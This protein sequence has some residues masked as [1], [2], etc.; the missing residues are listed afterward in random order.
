MT[1]VTWFNCTSGIAGDMA[2]GAL[3]DAGADLAAVE[4][5]LRALPVPGWH[6]EVS[7]VLRAGLAGTRALVVL[8]EADQPHRRWATIR[9]LLAGAELPDR[10]RQRALDT[11]RLLAEVEGRLHGV[12]PEDVHFHEVGAVDSIVDVVGVCLALEDLDIDQ[13]Q[14][15]PL[16]QGTGTVRAAHG[17]LPNP[18]P[19]VVELLARG[20]VP[21]YG[22]DE[23]MELTTPTGAALLVALASGFGPM[24][25]MAV[26]AS[27]FG[28]GGRDLPHRPNLVNVVV[29]EVA[30]AAP[31]RVDPLVVLETTLDDVSGE[32]LGWLVARLLEAGARDAWLAP[33]TMKKGRPGHVVTVLAEPHA[34]DAL[35]HL[36]VA[37]T[38]TLGVRWWPAD[39]WA[40]DR[41]VEEVEVDGHRIRLKVGP[42]GRAKPE[43][44]DVAAA[45]RA[46]RRPLREVA[47]A[48]L[49]A[50]PVAGRLDSARHND[51]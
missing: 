18:P 20:G 4:R 11:F 46:L 27:G 38:G 6:L 41:R 13:V 3:L 32:T 44:D 8:D 51:R 17:V 10:A 22:V 26:R 14:A 2:L 15:S 21:A 40:A 16:A 34:A 50:Q 7:R 23:P 19:A 25:A 45:A 43:H 35:R 28:A 5:G 42:G 36:L 39:R 1:T 24:P 33:V 12:A 47:A 48:A 31:G 30:A 9:D 37:E 29:G 49:A